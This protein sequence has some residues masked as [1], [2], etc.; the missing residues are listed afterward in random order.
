MT[1]GITATDMAG[2]TH[3][4]ATDGIQLHSQAITIHTGTYTTDTEAR[5]LHT[6]QL[7][8][9]AAAAIQEIWAM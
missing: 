5:R 9:E 1:L 7:P 4:G 2:T 3:G 8:A 6:I